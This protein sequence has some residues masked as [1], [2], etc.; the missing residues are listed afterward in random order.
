MYYITVVASIENEVTK[1]QNKALLSNNLVQIK[2]PPE[3]EKR[4]PPDYIEVTFLLCVR[5]SEEKKCV[6]TPV[7][8]SLLWY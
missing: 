1:K 5:D 2:R 8:Y 3:V 4:G 7:I 6:N